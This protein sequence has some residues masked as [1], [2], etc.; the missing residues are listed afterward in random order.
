MEL[1]LLAQFPN[2]ASA[3]GLDA[4]R[5]YALAVKDTQLAIQAYNRLQNNANMQAGDM[6]PCDEYLSD[7]QAVLLRIG[8]DALPALRKDLRNMNHEVAAMAQKLV[9]IIEAQK[10]PA[11]APF[12]KDRGK[13]ARRIAEA[14]L[15]CWD[16][17]D[18]GRGSKA[19]AAALE[20]L[21]ARGLQG[22][23]DLIEILASRSMRLKKEAA[24]A[25]ELLTGEKFGEDVAAWRAWHAEALEA[26]KRKPLPPDLADENLSIGLTPK[27]K[28]NPPKLLKLPE[29]PL[30]APPPED[31]Q[32]PAHEELLKGALL[33]EGLERKSEAEKSAA[34]EEAK[35][36][37]GG[38]KSRIED[39]E[40]D[41][42][43]YD[44]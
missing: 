9:G 17:A 43:R 5:R 1:A 4:Q 29:R 20:D 16:L 37:A 18:P 33:P 24:S 15:A 26:E 8:R 12:V 40:A 2:S 36:D 6:V 44:P 23:G 27:A 22:L 31:E 3:R 19:P 38:G 41:R 13:D 21:K 32:E 10:D 14:A 11:P 34:R 42:K 28:S 39:E 35:S 30:E 25:L 7:L